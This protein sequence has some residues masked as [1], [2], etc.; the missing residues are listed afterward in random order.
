MKGNQV[1]GI[2]MQGEE[3]TFHLQLNKLGER[4]KKYYLVLLLVFISYWEDS[5]TTSKNKEVK[6]KETVSLI[7]L[8]LS[9]TMVSPQF[10]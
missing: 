2:F 6:I 9:W 1:E 5:T 3:K 10:I 8:F 4:N 7:P